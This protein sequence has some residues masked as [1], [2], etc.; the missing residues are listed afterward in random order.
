MPKKWQKHKRLPINL[1]PQAFFM[2]YVYCVIFNA[3][4]LLFHDS[5]YL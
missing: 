5:T 3:V 4:H 1:I 2:I